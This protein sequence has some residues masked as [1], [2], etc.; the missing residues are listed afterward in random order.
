MPSLIRIEKNSCGNCGSPTTR[1]NIVRPKKSCC[2]VTL[3][4]IYCPVFSAKPQSDLNYLIAKKHSAPK[5]EDT[6]KC[7]LCYQEFRGF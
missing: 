5:P 2:A 3:Y 4:C 7:K 6:F 1:N